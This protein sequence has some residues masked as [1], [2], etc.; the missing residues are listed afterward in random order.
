MASDVACRMSC[1][2]VSVFIRLRGRRDGGEWWECPLCRLT[3]GSPTIAPRITSNI[4]IASVVSRREVNV[5]A[6]S[7][8]HLPHIVSSLP[9]PFFLFQKQRTT[10][11]SS[12]PSN[13]SKQTAAHS[14]PHTL[15]THTRTH[16]R[17][18]RPPRPS[19]LAPTASEV[20]Q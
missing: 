18:R 12:R 6:S 9:C 8:Q 10:Q 3:F 2:S 20:Q 14:H 15:K 11:S 19:T 13:L 1:S 4:H 7:L 5:E 17:N 16:T